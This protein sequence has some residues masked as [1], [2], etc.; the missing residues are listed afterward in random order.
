MILGQFLLTLLT[1]DA[2]GSTS[3]D[4]PIMISKSAS[5]KSFDI[6]SKNLLGRLSP[7]KTISG[8]ITVLHKTQ[9]GTPAASISCFN[10]SNEYVLLHFIQCEELN[11]P[12][13]STSFSSLIPAFLSRPSTFCV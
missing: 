2:N 13:A 12:C 8:L 9:V 1:N 5:G 10:H 11:E 3:N 6:H 7:K 4:D